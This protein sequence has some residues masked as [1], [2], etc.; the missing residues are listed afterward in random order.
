MN[1]KLETTHTPMMRRSPVSTDNSNS[2]SN[3]NTNSKPTT[4]GSNS[5]G[6]INSEPGVFIPDQ[7]VSSVTRKMFLDLHCV[8]PALPSPSNEQTHTLNKKS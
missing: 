7:P 4:S 3:S 5:V 6:S 8:P 1:S 2:N